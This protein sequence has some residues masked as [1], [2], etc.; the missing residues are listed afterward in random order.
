[1]TGNTHCVHFNV[2]KKEFNE[3]ALAARMMRK[4][5]S[6]LIREAVSQYLSARKNAVPAQD[7]YSQKIN[8]NDIA[9]VGYY[10]PTKNF[11]KPGWYLAIRKNGDE[12]LDYIYYFHGNLTSAPSYTQ[13]V[14]ALMQYIL[15]EE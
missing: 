8:E 9:V 5:K 4:T 12:Q 10:T 7:L 15:D 2:S 11:M 14:R 13:F 6:Q 3:Y 1:M